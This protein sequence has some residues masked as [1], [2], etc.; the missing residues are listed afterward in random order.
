MAAFWIDKIQH[1][2]H[3]AFF[4]Q[5]MPGI[6]QQFSL[7]V[8]NYKGSVRLHDVWFGIEAGFASA[9]TAADQD[10]QISPVLSSVQAQSCFLCQQL[11]GISCLMVTL[12]DGTWIS[13]AGRTLFLTPPINPF[14]GNKN[15]NAHAIEHKKRQHGFQAALAPCNLERILQC[16]TEP[17]QKRS[18]SA[19]QQR[20]AQERKPDHR[21][22]S[23]DIEN[24][25]LF[26]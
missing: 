21:D 11:V 5:Q 14:I 2:H 18:Q 4:L 24:A 6:P 1:L 20:G 16:C 7:R 10:I 12:A 22:D 15:A 13:P 26:G 17:F 9:G 19:V 25:A 23:A 8:K 3:I